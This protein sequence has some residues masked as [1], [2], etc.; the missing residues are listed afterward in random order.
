MPTSNPLER[1]STGELRR[2]TSLKWRAHPD[3]VLPPWV[4]EMDVTPVPAVVEAV[5]TAM[6]AGDTGYPAGDDYAHALAEFA[7]DPDTSA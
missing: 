1:L 5:T 7:A 4:A 2:R 6:Q 3:D